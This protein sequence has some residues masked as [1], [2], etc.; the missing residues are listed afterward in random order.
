VLL[1]FAVFLNLDGPGRSPGERGDSGVPRSG[2][3]RGQ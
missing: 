1:I 2:K 3:R